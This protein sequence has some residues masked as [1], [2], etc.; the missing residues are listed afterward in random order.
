[1]QEEGKK[2]KEKGKGEKGKDLNAAV[3][4]TPYQHIVF[5]FFLLLTF[6]LFPYFHWPGSYTK[7]L[8]GPRLTRMMHQPR[9][10]TLSQKVE[11]CLTD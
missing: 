1:M 4:T 6:P 8:P 2:E 10:G 7:T 9:Q 3:I 11:S 5:P